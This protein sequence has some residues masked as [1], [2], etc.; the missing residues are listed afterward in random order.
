MK[1]KIKLSDETSTKRPHRHHKKI[2]KIATTTET[3]LNC[4]SNYIDSWCD[5]L[6]PF[7]KQYLF[8]YTI[9]D[10]YYLSKSLSYYE[11]KCVAMNKYAKCIDNNFAH[12]KQMIGITLD[13]L[14]KLN[15]KCI[16]INTKPKISSAV[17][18]SSNRNYLNRFLIIFIF[19]FNLR[20]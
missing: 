1:D 14:D 18:K 9:D 20:F 19:G 8:N 6:D 3:Q 7:L 12:C 2:K 15:R 17:N 13:R 10:S 5:Q 4:E 16:L 11:S